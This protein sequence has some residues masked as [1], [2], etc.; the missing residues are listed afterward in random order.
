[1]K[2]TTKSQII[3]EAAEIISCLILHKEKSSL[4]S[5]AE[6]EKI[7]HFKN[8]LSDETKNFLVDSFLS[9]Y[10][11]IEDAPPEYTLFEVKDLY[12]KML[13][14]TEKEIEEILLYEY[15]KGIDKMNCE[16]LEFLLDCYEKHLYYDNMEEANEV[17]DKYI[18]A[19]QTEIKS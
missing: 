7:T 3:N 11:N 1:M 2:E 14:F 8:N 19:C 18:E 9:K 13:Y 17:F 10:L 6:T 15:S 5:E 4:F 12:S 16:L